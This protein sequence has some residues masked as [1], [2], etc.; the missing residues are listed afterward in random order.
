MREQ[1]ALAIEDFLV[2]LIHGIVRLPLRFF[3]ACR[4]VAHLFAK[5]FDGAPGG[6]YAFEGELAQ[7]IAPH[8]PV[9][10]HK[11]RRMFVEGDE[12]AM[13]RWSLELRGYIE[14]CVLPLMGEERVYADRN[15]GVVADVLDGLIAREQD[16]PAA[17]N[18]EQLLP[19]VIPNDSS[20]A[21]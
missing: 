6:R 13:Q 9:L 16:K 18:T 14:S 1:M 3:T 8:L 19:R 21:T 2:D 5:S 4:E 7:L 10:A 17:W 12:G 20:W 11:R 15:R